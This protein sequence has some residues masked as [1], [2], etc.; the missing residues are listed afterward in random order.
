MRPPH[1]IQQMFANTFSSSEGRIVLGWILT[2][3]QV[4]LP[5]DPNNIDQIRL[6]LDNNEP[7]IVAFYVSSSF[8][9]MWDYGDP[10][11]PDKNIWRTQVGPYTDAHCVCIVGY[12]NNTKLFKVQNSWGATNSASNKPGEGGYFWVTYDLVEQ[13]CFKEAYSLIPAN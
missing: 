8:T 5:L 6:C 13:G 2:E 11:L 3:G 4:L 10:S 1:E 7:V 9:N 12:D